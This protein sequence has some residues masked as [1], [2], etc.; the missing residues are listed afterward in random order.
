MNKTMHDGHRKRMRETYLTSGFS[1]F[2]EIEKLEY[3]LFSIIPRGD[4]NP[5]A[6]ELIDRFGSLTGVFDADLDDLLNIKGVG[7]KTAEFL[8]SIPSICELYTSIKTSGNK[9]LD[10]LNKQ[11]EF[12]W[13]YVRKYQEE[14]FAIVSLD[15]KYMFKAFDIVSTGSI[16]HV[17]IDIRKL[18]EIAIKRK[19]TKIILVHN[20]PNHYAIESNDDIEATRKI[21][22][23]VNPLSI[24]VADHLIFSNDDCLSLKEKGYL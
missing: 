22:K 9:V 19:A 15:S 20:H 1:A 3:I 23:I 2:S 14:I 17:D 4:T 6:H 11:K 24:I 7:P 18:T 10:N 5:L 12:I 21:V 16:N 8:T 13:P